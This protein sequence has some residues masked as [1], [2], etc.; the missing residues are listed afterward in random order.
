MRLYIY[1]F[2]RPEVTQWRMCSAF[3]FHNAPC[4]MSNT[5]S[6]TWVEESLLEYVARYLKVYGVN[7]KLCESYAWLTQQDLLKIS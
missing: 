7:S 6:G 5:K 2:M 3:I 1:A 4:F